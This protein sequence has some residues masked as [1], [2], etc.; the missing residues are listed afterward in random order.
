MVPPLAKVCAYN[1][2]RYKIEP[3]R[4]GGLPGLFALQGSNTLA[5]AQA[6]RRHVP[7][8]VKCTATMLLSSRANTSSMC[9]V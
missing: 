9:M 7:V 5:S 1:S 6:A 3:W 8:Q 2:R 4:A